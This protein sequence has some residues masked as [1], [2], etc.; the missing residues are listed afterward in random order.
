MRSGSHIQVSAPSDRPL[1]EYPPPTSQC[2]P[3]NQACSST[4]VA[5]AFGCF[6]P[7]RRLKR[8][9]SFVNR[10]RL[11]REAHVRAQVDVVKLVVLAIPETQ[12][13][14][15]DAERTDRVP[16]ANEVELG[17]GP[18]I[19][20]A[21]RLGTIRIGVRLVA[22]IAV[23][24]IGLGVANQVLL[25]QDATVLSWPARLRTVYAP[26]LKPS[27]NSSSPG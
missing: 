15:G 6:A 21:K 4:C 16:D 22:A 2:T 1:S 8:L 7:E 5:G 24:L 17:V 3:G 10:Q 14:Y 12:R 26:R 19:F 18:A 25:P 9:A 20:G 27:R 23:Q 11:V 13:G